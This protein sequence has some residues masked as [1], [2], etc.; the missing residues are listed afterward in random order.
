MCTNVWPSLFTID[1]LYL[2]V[3]HG[4]ANYDETNSVGCHALYA[5]SIRMFSSN[6]SCRIVCIYIYIL[7]TVKA[8]VCNPRSG[9]FQTFADTPLIICSA[10]CAH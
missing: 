2:H 1:I 7:L 4:V 3:V 6:N 8:K 5:I 10:K 9:I